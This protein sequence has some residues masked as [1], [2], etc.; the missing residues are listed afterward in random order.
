MK[1]S[2]PLIGLA[3]V[4]LLGALIVGSISLVGF[5]YWWRGTPQYSLNQ[6]NKAVQA[7]DRELFRKHVDIRSVAS[8]LIDDLMIGKSGGDELSAGLVGLMKPQLLVSWEDQVDRLVETG[9]FE[10]NQ[11]F[12]GDQS[13][14]TLYGEIVPRIGAIRELRRDGKVALLVLELRPQNNNE[15]PSIV[16]LKMRKTEDGYWQLMEVSLPRPASPASP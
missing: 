8:R 6:I 4:A 2:T 5:E 9:G 16:D 12:V 11:K 14:K 13:L 7:H 3:L 1:T 15:K 10:S